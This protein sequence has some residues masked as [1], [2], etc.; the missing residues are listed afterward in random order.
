MTFVEVMVA[1]LVLSIALLGAMAYRYYSAA[2]A[3]RADVHTTAARL[4]SMLLEDWKADWQSAD[5]PQADSTY[6][7]EEKFDSDINI[8][9]S[10]TDTS[11]GLDKP[12][13]FDMH[14]NGTIIADN[15]TYYVTLS[16]YTPDTTPRILNVRIGWKTNYQAGTI[17][18]TDPFVELTT[19]MDNS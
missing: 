13:G 16:Y 19:Y 8:T 17:S 18:S 6:N 14:G 7:P 4:A 9:F 3:K 10:I 5:D 12:S 2:D 15:V 1:V 11:S